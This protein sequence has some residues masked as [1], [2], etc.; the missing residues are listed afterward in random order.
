MSIKDLILCGH[1][2]GGAV[3]QLYY[4]THPNDVRALIL[5]GTGARLRVSPVTLNSSKNNY[6][7]YLNSLRAGAFYRKTSKDIKDEIVNEVSKIEPN[8]TYN[9]FKIC[10]NF[11]VM[12]KINSIKVPCLIICGA[13]DNLT[14]PKYSRY[15]H[16]EIKNSELSII[17]KA[18]H[19]LMVEKPIELNNAIKNFIDNYL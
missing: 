6:E 7:E 12:Q 10:D 9:D 19:Y 13:A 11:D 16:E 3:I 1:S 14:P 2:L 17:N 15:F 5:V 18:G 8:V 4:F